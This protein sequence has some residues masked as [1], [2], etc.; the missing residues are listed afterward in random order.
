MCSLHWCTDNL[1]FVM[2]LHQQWFYFLLHLDVVEYH[3]SYATNSANVVFCLPQCL[4]IE[5]IIRI[6]WCGCFK[7][8]TS[9][10][11]LLY[12]YLTFNEIYFNFNEIY[13]IE[14]KCFAMSDIENQ[15]L[16]FQEILWYEEI[17][18]YSY[19]LTW[20]F[21]TSIYFEL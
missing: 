17:F 11:K 13:K 16:Y 10:Y 21:R 1:F 8:T 7:E 6:S 2:W 9:S 20:Y 5:A 14:K 19:F 12:L 18:S 15:L 4:F 3:E